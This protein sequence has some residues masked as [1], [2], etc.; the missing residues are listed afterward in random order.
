[1]ERA[2]RLF[3][4]SVEDSVKTTISKQLTANSILQTANSK[5]EIKCKSKSKIKQKS[6][7]RIDPSP[8]RNAA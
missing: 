3:Y 1:M 4:D 7:P 8:D 5:I 6:K 2:L